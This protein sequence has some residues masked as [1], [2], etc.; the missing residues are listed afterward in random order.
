MKYEVID[1]F[2]DQEDFKI[3]HSAIYGNLNFPWFLFDDKAF[4]E[5]EDA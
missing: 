2:L 5:K 4:G 3:I 1:N